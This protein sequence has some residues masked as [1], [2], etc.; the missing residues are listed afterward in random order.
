[1]PRAGRGELASE[2]LGRVAA[3]VAVGR[4]IRHRVHTDLGQHQAV[5]L[6]GR[7]DDPRQHQLP[8]H[9]IATGRPSEPE[10]VIRAAQPVPQMPIREDA[11][12]NGLD[13]P[14]AAL[15]EASKPGSNSACPPTK[16]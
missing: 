8:E 10:Q 4:G 5:G 9:L 12:S 14:T 13:E 11:I 1:M 15:I 2:T 16:R 7:L 6:A 3:Q